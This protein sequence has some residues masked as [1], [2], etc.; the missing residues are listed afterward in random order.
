MP[1]YNPG[2]SRGQGR[3]GSTKLFAVV[4]FGR[5]RSGAPLDRRLFERR[6][7]GLL[8]DLLGPWGAFTRIASTSDVLVVTRR[9]TRVGIRCPPDVLSSV[10]FLADSDVEL[11]LRARGLRC[12]PPVKAERAKARERLSSCPEPASFHP[13]A[14]CPRSFRMLEPTRTVSPSAH[15]RPASVELRT[16]SWLAPSLFHQQALRPPGGEDA[17]CVQPMSATQTNHVHPHL[18]RS[19]LTLATFAAGDAPRSLRLRQA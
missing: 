15:P 14:A 2:H 3:R 1:S 10:V 9:H 19:R 7:C 18:A 12:A 6:G 4:S 11:N 8:V 17:R 5:S 16:S 13:Q